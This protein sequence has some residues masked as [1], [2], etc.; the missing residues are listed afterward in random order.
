MTVRTGLRVACTVALLL[1]SLMI[2]IPASAAATIYQ[3]E[4][5]APLF[6]LPQA[7]G[8]PADGMRF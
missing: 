6:G 7:N 3:V 1:G 8:A 2:A 5:G 4:V